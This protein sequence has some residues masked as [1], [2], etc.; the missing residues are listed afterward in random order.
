MNVVAGFWQIL[1]RKQSEVTTSGYE[2][3]K[4]C[5]YWVSSIQGDAISKFAIGGLG[6]HEQEK[7]F[8]ISQTH[9]HTIRQLPRAAYIRPETLIVADTVYG[10]WNLI[11]TLADTLSCW[12]TESI[13]VLQGRFRYYEVDFP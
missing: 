3:F 8:L 9:T 1:Y 5:I 10:T 12:S 6:I 2:G 13:P 4:F 11:E 7:T